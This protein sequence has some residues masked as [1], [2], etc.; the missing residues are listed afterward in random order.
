MPTFA[1]MIALLVGVIWSSIGV[2]MRIC[3]IN[4]IRRAKKSPR[5]RGQGGLGKNSEIEYQAAA[6]LRAV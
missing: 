1:R 5:G 4:S 3:P 2:S 6:A